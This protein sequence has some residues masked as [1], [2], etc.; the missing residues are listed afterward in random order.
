MVV[1]YISVS[2]HLEVEKTEA[3]NDCPNNRLQAASLNSRCDD[4]EVRTFTGF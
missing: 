3:Q 1:S 2:W 4:V